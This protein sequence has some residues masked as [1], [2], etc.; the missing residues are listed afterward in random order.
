[1]LPL[2]SV[3]HEAMHQWDDKVDAALEAQAAR[4]GVALAKDVSHALVFYTVGY[5]I[6]QR[7]PE[8]EPLMDAANIWRGTL[9][10]GCA[11]VARLRSVLEGTWKA[12][13]EGKGTRDDAFAAVIAAAR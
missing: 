10:G 13:I 2:E 12:Y 3:F 1:W 11:P 6:R 4:Q 9:S 5:V 7:H 8:H